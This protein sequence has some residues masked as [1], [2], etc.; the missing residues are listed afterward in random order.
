MEIPNNN[1]TSKVCSWGVTTRIIIIIAMLK[2]I[3]SH[4]VLYKVNLS[5]I[6]MK[7]L[8]SICS[9]CSKPSSPF[10]PTASQLEIIRQCVCV[11]FFFGIISL[12]DW[13]GFTI[14]SS[15]CRFILGWF[16][17]LGGFCI[18]GVSRSSSVGLGMTVGRGSWSDLRDRIRD[19]E[20]I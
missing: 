7:V 17:R 12:R 5:T 13:L 20:C 10:I 19:P 15:C 1:C 3:I 16:F 4:S 6:C 2:I 8:S 14:R 18:F 9:K 11:T